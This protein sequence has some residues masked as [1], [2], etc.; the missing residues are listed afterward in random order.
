[1]AMITE[2]F[3]R[4]LVLMVFRYIIYIA[5][6]KTTS[7]ILGILKENEFC[8]NLSYFKKHHSIRVSKYYGLTLEHRLD[9]SS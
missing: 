9:E 8:S 1:M 7:L 4:I 5:V 3:M 6:N 2:L